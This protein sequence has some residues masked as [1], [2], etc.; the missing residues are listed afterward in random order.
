MQDIIHCAIL[1]IKGTIPTSIK[2]LIL[3]INVANISIDINLF[4]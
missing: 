2:Q 3:G 4:T 1:I